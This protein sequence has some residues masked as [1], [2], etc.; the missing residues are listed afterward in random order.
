MR[1]ILASTS[2]YRKQL[3]QRLRV[4]FEQCSPDFAELQPG[5]MNAS[6]LVL[7]NTLGKA[8]S[9]FALNPDAV[10]IAS[11][12]LA[13]CG[14][15]VVGKAGDIDRACE[16]L[17]MLSGRCVEF[18]TGLCLLSSSKQQ[19]AIIPYRVYFRTLN[20]ME[21]RHYVE[22]EQPIDCAG[23]FKSEGLGISLFERME[24][25]DP[26]ALI[27]LPLICLSQWLQPLK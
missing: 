16:Q 23:S 2:P 18:I 1:L 7:H 25:D 8:K 22:A 21:I 14:D 13:V 20:K 15:L 10:V 26:T 11:D 24:G 9:V 12:Q 3:L 19:S 4:P 17:E 6:D 27:G 5:A